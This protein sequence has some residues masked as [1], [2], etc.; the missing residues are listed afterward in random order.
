MCQIEA[1]E[2]QGILVIVV[3]VVMVVMVVMV[4]N[5]RMNA[6]AAVTNV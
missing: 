6:I 2:C 3:I 4:W 5:E 1:V